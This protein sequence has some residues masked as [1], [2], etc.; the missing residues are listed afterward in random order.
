MS[1]LLATTSDK[2]GYPILIQTANPY[3]NECSPKYPGTKCFSSGDLRVNQH[4]VLMTLHVVFVRRHNQHALALKKVNPSWNDEKLFQEARRILIA[5]FQLITYKE[6]LPIVFG[7]TLMDYFNLN[8]RYSGYTVYEP[9]T[10]PTS[11]NDYATAACRFG[12]SQIQGWF[13]IYGKMPNQYHG[14]GYWLRDK[15]FDPSDIYEGWVST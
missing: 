8:I 12:H 4:P 3:R 11:W 5:E 1:G 13:G 6:Y 9:Y 14:R 2:Y 7:P 10:D 15:F